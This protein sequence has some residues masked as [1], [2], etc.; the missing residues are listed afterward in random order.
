MSKYERYSPVI[1]RNADENISADH[2]LKQFEKNL[3]KSAVQPRTQNS[4]FDQINT[5]MNRKSKYPTVDAAVEDM[6][7]RSGL[8]AYLDKEKQ[9][10]DISSKAIVIKNA[11]EEKT[12][13]IIISLK[14]AVRGSD[15]R[16]AGKLM[17]DLELVEGNPTTNAMDNV[18]AFKHFYDPE[19]KHVKI[20]MDAWED[21][22][23]GYC[24]GRGMNEETTHQQL[25]FTKRIMENHGK[26]FAA[27][28]NQAIDKHIPIVI[29]KYP[30]IRKTLENCIRD[31][32]G[33]MSIPAIIEKIRSIHQGD[34]SEAKDWD[35]DKLIYLVSN[36]NLEAKKNNP[37]TYENYSNLGSRDSN[38]N[39]EIDA[40]N[41][42]AFNAL[43]PA[44]I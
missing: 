2:W 24:Q 5:I 20:P 22:T 3:Q 43:N 15:W 37:S 21:F 11:G 42:D 19:L 23:V 30:P 32:K 12:D 13:N 34:V 4:L 33:N 26:K 18:V 8:T 29:K 9:A 10:E 14:E 17:A 1:S 27:D 44:K 35:E 38:C 6:K 36:L 25:K 7:N 41:T 16:N 31:S 40:S 28:E 39:Q